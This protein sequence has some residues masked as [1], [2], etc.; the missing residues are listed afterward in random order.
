MNV[1][2]KERLDRM[3]THLRL[4]KEDLQQISIA[5]MGS[6]MNG[7]RGIVHDVKDMMIE[8]TALR[9]KV[10]EL[11]KENVKKGVIIDILKAVSVILISGVATLIVNIFSK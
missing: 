7:N 4:I 8:Q 2:E 9:N 10:L 1:E 5:L 3:E 11:E 6:G